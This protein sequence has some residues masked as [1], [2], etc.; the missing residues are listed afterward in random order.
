MDV[1]RG[2]SHAFMGQE[3]LMNP[4]EG[5]LG[6]TYHDNDWQKRFLLAFLVLL[7]ICWRDGLNNIKRLFIL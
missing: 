4:L 2:S 5:L 7:K 3:R 6:A 1:L